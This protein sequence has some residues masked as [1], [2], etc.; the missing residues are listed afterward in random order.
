MMV[1]DPTVDKHRYSH[2]RQEQDDVP[3]VSG[4]GIEALAA[5][6]ALRTCRRGFLQAILALRVAHAVC[7][8]LQRD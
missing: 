6:G 7:P 1:N 2:H 4:E 3:I 5:G 8:A